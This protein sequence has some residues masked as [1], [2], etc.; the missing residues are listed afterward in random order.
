[1]R[2]IEQSL[3]ALD[4][5]NLDPDQKLA[6]WGI[7][8][9]YVFGSALHTDESLTRAATAQR[10]PGLVADAINFGR[11]QLQTGQFPHLASLYHQQT[12]DRRS[13]NAAPPMT[14]DLLRAQFE[15]GLKALLDG[16]TLDTIPALDATLIQPPGRHGQSAPRR[17][18]ADRDDPAR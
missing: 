15:Q 16:L 3:A 2:H 1:M 6:V 4:D 7:V 17:A 12:G 11:Q 13:P 9:D 8:D 14:K 10:N 5:L 18:D